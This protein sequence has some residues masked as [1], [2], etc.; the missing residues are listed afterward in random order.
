MSTFPSLAYVIGNTP[1]V[2]FR[3][4]AKF[5]GLNSK[6]YGKLEASN[7]V[8][9]V[10]DRVAN[11]MISAAEKSGILKKGSTIIEPSSGN[12]GIALAAIGKSK[13]YDVIITMPDSMSVERQKLLKLYGAQ[14]VLT[15]KNLGMRGAIDKAEEL[16][17]NIKDAFIPDQFKN[18]VNPEVH[19]KTTGPEIFQDIGYD[20]DVFIAG[21]GTGGT[22]T[23]VGEFL[24]TRKPQ[25]KVIAVEPA[26][27]PILSK[28]KSG[29]HKIQGIGAGFV[30]E[31]LNTDIY[32]EVIAV[33]D[34][35]AL[36]IRYE[37]AV[38]EGLL[39]GISSGAAIAAALK[40]SKRNKSAKFNIVVIL[41]DT[42]ERYLSLT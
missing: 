17:S 11:A 18:P 31:I 24:K 41:P 1:L 39:L 10:K 21:V 12:T 16:A 7:P 5:K 35:E 37:V 15:N 27:S 13:G 20:I 28:G 4:Y 40:F 42:G 33:E 38:S 36:K 14:V 29:P 30:P 32:D 9:S 34:D 3:N 22:I 2:E 6:I 19:R 8:G 25:I 26:G 23:G